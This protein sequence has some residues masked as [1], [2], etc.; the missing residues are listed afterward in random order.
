[1]RAGLGRPGGWRWASDPSSLGAELAPPVPH[2]Y[3]CRVVIQTSSLFIH[4]SFAPF[5]LR[6]PGT[7]CQSSATISTSHIHIEEIEEIV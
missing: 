4:D 2:E 5:K 6:I 3:G 1:M 7:T